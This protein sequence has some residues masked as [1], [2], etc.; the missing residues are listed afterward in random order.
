[1]KLI[2]PAEPL[3]V[4]D[5]APIDAAFVVVSEIDPVVVICVTVPILEFVLTN[6]DTEYEPV[7]VVKFASD[8]PAVRVVTPLL[9][10][11]FNTLAVTLFKV[12]V[13]G[14][15][16]LVTFSC[17]KVNPYRLIVSG[18]APEVLR[19]LTDPPV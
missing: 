16:V 13:A 15:V 5:T 6:V 18:Y 17:P 4:I 9:P 10:V 8:V 12:V 2:F 3:L 11:M 19:V 1:V 14:C 7:L